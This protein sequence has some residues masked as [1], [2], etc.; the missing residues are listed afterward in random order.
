MY[1]QSII[2]ISRVIDSAWV[3][4]YEVDFIVEGPKELLTPILRLPHL[5]HGHW[6][7]TVYPSIN[8]K[9]LTP[10]AISIQQLL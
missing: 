3:S 5:P 6:D 9:E 1:I 7:V 10:R 8:V 4:P 2:I